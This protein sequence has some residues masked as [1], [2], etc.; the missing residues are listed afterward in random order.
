MPVAQPEEPEPEDPLVVSALKPLAG[1]HHLT[2]A[3]RPLSQG[4]E[5]G[6]QPAVAQLSLVDVKPAI[7]TPLHHHTIMTS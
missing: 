4:G 5:G 2:D 1:R 3:V 6:Q 7:I